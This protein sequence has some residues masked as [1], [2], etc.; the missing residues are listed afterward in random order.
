[1]QHVNLNAYELAI[2]SS[3]KELNRLSISFGSADENE[4][5]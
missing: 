5:H 3:S 4:S 2:F 1:M